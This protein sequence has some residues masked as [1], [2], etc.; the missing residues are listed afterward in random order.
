MTWD[1]LAFAD[2]HMTNR[3]SGGSLDETGTNSFLRCIKELFLQMLSRAL[4]EDCILVCAGDFIDSTSL[5]PITATVVHEVF[6]KA[7]SMGIPFLI[8][9]GN[10]EFDGMRSLVDAYNP[11]KFKNIRMIANPRVTKIR[12][13]EFYCVPYIGPS[14]E[15]LQHEVTTMIRRAK[16]SK[17][18]KKVLLLHFPIVGGKF[19]ASNRRL[20]SGFNLRAILDSEGHPFTC[21]L[22][23]DFHDRQ[24][25]KGVKR[26]MYLGQPY[27]GNFA[28][29]GKK[30]GYTLMDLKANKRRLVISKACPRYIV[31]PNVTSVAQLSSKMDIEGNV[32]RAFI[33][34]EMQ[35][36]T[37]SDKLLQLGAVKAQIRRIKKKAKPLPEHDDN[38]SLSDQHSATIRDFVSKH[39][40]DGLPV[41]LVSELAVGLY[42]EVREA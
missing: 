37:V 22:A 38:Y 10:H 39:C 16:I 28:A 11:L 4:K 2:L 12:D 29:V 21:I 32:V 40:P 35:A 5:D 41:K 25:L 26:F 18:K 17:V 15:R 19:D 42:E 34:P 20:E 36:S 27:Q 31:L 3:H 14:V 13:I 24:K 8:L 6:E 1:L 9:G 7:E 33:E 23:G 30:R